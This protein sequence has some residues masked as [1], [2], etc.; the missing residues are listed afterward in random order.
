MS[1]KKRVEAIQWWDELPYIDKW[2]TI[3]KHK[4]KVTG[5]PD[6]HPDSLT[7]REI[8]MLHSQELKEAQL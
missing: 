8:E 6:R 4:Y 3:V 7:G 5:Y 2:K 1:T